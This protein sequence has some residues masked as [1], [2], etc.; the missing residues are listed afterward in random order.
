MSE[1]RVTFEHARV[2]KIEIDASRTLH[3]AGLPGFP[4]ARSFA[5]V[6]HDEESAFAWLASLDRPDLA[7]VVAEPG[8][9]FPDV[10][11]RLA[12][13]ELDAVGA[14]SREDVL[15]LAIANLSGGEACLNLAAPIVVNVHTRRAAQV[16]L[17]DASLPLRA[18]LG[19]REPAAPAQIESKPH[20]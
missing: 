8:K 17:P 18:R 20:R 3:F 14:A 11:L 13:R 9:L 6:H 16:V 19:A 4:A 12:R 5:L 2:G 10:Q 1:P 7:F 15:V